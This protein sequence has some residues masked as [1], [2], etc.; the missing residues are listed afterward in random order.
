MI[1]FLALFFKSNSDSSITIGNFKQ[2]LE[3]DQYNEES[4]DRRQIKPGFIEF[5]PS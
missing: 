4:S 2:T 5:E 1:L 3:A